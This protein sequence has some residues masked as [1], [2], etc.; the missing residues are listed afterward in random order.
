MSVPER[1]EA[2]V[3]QAGKTYNIW[4]PL[5]SHKAAEQLA[6]LIDHANPLPTAHH[7]LLH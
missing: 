6:T 7:H 1:L 4:S 2:K 5:N 3:L